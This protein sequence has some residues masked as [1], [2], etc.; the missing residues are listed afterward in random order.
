VKTVRRTLRVNRAR[1]LALPNVYGLMIGQKTAGHQ[2]C[3]ELA[4][5]VLV[6]AKGRVPKS[7]AVPRRLRAIGAGRYPLRWYIKTDVEEIGSP[8]RALGVR[9]GDRIECRRR[10]TAGLA[11]RTPG[12]N[13]VLL[14]NAHVVARPDRWAIGDDVIVTT[15][16]ADVV[17]G[18]VH[19][20]TRIRTDR[21]NRCDAALV[22]LDVAADLLTVGTQGMRVGHY[23]TLPSGSERRFFY[24][25]G[26]TRVTCTHPQRVES[27][28]SIEYENGA[29]ASFTDFV[30]LEVTSGT[31]VES[32]SGSLLMQEHDDEFN[33]CGLL[34]AGNATRIAVLR[35][36]DVVASLS[37][38]AASE[39]GETEDVSV[40][41]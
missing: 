29:T 38:G 21:D 10:G 3:G 32:H 20:M 22:K 15:P 39:L 1:L 8:L 17:C 9:G 27:P 37:S 6:S 2:R 5:R 36:R 23:G 18:T 34:F 19:R 41:F 28:V 25:S 24:I 26:G 7:H 33:A 31:P 35:I 14:T 30:L 11:Y 13:T 12:G 40:R 16:G 4:I